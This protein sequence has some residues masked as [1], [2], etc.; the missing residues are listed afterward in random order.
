[1]AEGPMNVI[2]GGAGIFDDMIDEP[3]EDAG[4]KPAKPKS[5]P[6]SPQV[7]KN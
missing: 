3:V 1:M 6:K 5:P 2:L 4:T 7:H